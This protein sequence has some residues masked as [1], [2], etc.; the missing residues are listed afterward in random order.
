MTFEEIFEEQARKTKLLISEE[1]IAKVSTP[2]LDFFDEEECEKIKALHKKLL[3]T[4]MKDNDSNEV[5]FLVNLIDWT[6][7]PTLGG[8]RGI[9][10]RSNPDAKELLITAPAHSLVFLHNHPRNSVFS[11]RD[12]NSFLTTDAI[13]MV[14]VVCN[15]GRTYY[16][17]KSADYN[18]EDAL[19][20]YDDLFENEKIEHT[21][22]EFLR[23]CKK[24][25]LSFYYGGV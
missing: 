5:G 22:K 12:L 19:K 4:A 7:L 17:V 23:T 16:L 1:Y 10:I 18:T 3:E 6:Y 14:T 13:L 9:T 24:V 15:N 8:E 11:E 2:K 21:V 25:G 20:Y